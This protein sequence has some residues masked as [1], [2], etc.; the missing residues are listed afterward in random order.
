[1]HQYLTFWAHKRIYFINFLNKNSP[2]PPVLLKIFDFVGKYD[3]GLLEC[4][5]QYAV[6]GLF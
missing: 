2:I 6:A 5:I 1:M 3:E 4:K